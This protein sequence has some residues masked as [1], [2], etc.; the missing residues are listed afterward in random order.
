MTTI[1]MKLPAHLSDWELTGAFRPPTNGEYLYSHGHVVAARGNYSDPAL[2]VRRR[3]KP[4]ESA[5]LRKALEQANADNAKLLEQRDALAKQLAEQTDHKKLADENYESWKAAVESHKRANRRINSLIAERDQ[6]QLALTTIAKRLSCPTD[7]VASVVDAVLERQTE[8]LAER[9]NLRSDVVSLRHC[10]DLNTGVIKELEAE[11]DQLHVECKRLK[12]CGDFAGWNP[13]V[14]AE[15]AAEHERQVASITAECDQLR[16]TKN[17]AIADNVKSMWLVESL[18]A[19]RDNLKTELAECRA[20]LAA[21]KAIEPPTFEVGKC[22]RTTKGKLVRV[23][24]DDGLS[25]P[26]MCVSHDSPDY[27][28][29][30]WYR[31]DGTEHTMGG[32]FGNL[33]P[34]PQKAMWEGFE[35][36]VDGKYWKTDNAM[37]WM[38]KAGLWRM[39]LLPGLLERSLAAGV[40]NVVNGVGTLV[41]SEPK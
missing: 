2:I 17:D 21:A 15:R 4:V 29:C 28:P 32:M 33:L 26:L 3:K 36:L 9:D 6:Y 24:C 11:R 10:D 18:T 14:V 1:D 16:Q 8:L 34:G 30:S 41:E 31:I 23:V 19:E 38:D 5:M 35:C 25:V 37:Y 22:Y 12:F 7:Q 13:V 40:Y 20:E 27:G 39:L